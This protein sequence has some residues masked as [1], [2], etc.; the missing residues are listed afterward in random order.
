MTDVTI[1][2]FE[3]PRPLGRGLND[4][5]KTALAANQGKK[6]WSINYRP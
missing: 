3:L 1:I 4:P 2:L 6:Y 5:G